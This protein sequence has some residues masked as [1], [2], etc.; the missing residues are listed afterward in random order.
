FTCKAVIEAFGDDIHEGDV[1]AINDPDLGGTH[2]NDVRIIR[3]IFVDGRSIAYA[4]ANG[5]WADVGGSV[6]G[7]FDVNA[8]EHFGE[9]LRITPVRVYD[10][11]RYCDDV[12]RMIVSNTRGPEGNE[13]DLHSQ[14]EATAVA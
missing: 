14:V 9:G 10:A 12:V 11:G 5:H 2:F 4:Q 7:S 13:G 1:F 3:P 6:P 8:K